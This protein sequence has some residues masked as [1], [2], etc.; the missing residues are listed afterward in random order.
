MDAAFQESA[1]VKLDFVKKHREKLY[2]VAE[3]LVETF[4]SGRK[5]L[6][7]GNG[8]SSCD[9][10]H[11]VG[12]FVN[13]FM[14]DRRPLPAIALT[15][16]SSILTS[17]ANDYSY[18]DVFARQIHALGG[19]RDVAFGIST[20]GN[21]KNVLLAMGAAKE[22]GLLTVGLTG[23]DGGKLGPL[24]DYHLNVGLGK[25][26]RIQETHIVI[27]HLL[28]EIVDHVLFEHPFLN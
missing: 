20:S 14:K 9:A 5:I 7:F 3:V 6:A 24:V 26:P 10:Q 8:G 18:E 28:C 25:T 12:E 27:I 2:V 21:S 16:D 1:E 23:Y 15:A 17:C 22:K 13:R 4:R 11:F 19:S